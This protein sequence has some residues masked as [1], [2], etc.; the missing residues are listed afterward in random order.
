MTKQANPKNK[1]RHRCLNELKDGDDDEEEEYI[2]Y[3]NSASSKSSSVLGENDVDEDT[4]IKTE[5]V[6]S[7]VDHRIIQFRYISNLIQV[8]PD[9]VFTINC[10]GMMK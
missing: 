2:H 6:Q 10:E 5:A 7:L 8:F 1:R 3:H 4:Y 9:Q